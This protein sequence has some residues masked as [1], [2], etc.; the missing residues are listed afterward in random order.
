MATIKRVPRLDFAWNF[1]TLASIP[2]SPYASAVRVASENLACHIKKLNAHNRHRPADI[3]WANRR[4][5]R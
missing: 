1:K 3:R 2:F 5:L 4:M